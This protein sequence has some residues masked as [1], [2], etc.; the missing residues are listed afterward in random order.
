MSLAWFSTDFCERKCK[1]RKFHF[2]LHD[3]CMRVRLLRVPATRCPWA[4]VWC[5]PRALYLN[6][7]GL[8]VILCCAVFC[9]L[10]MYAFYADCDPW[11]AGRVSAPDQV[12]TLVSM[13]LLILVA[14]K[15]GSLTPCFCCDPVRWSSV[16]TSTAHAV[17]CD[18]DPG[19]VPRAARAVCGVCLQWNPQVCKARV[20]Q[21]VQVQVI[22][23]VNCKT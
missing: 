3:C 9:G 13:S 2:S 4:W 18:G 19:G 22:L 12:C 23:F 11:S 7:L 20:V 10:I 1:I 8:V 16:L 17:L 14:Q 15:K 6:L 21:V 5:V